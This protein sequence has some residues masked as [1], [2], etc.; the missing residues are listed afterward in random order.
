[1]QA[2]F[3]DSIHDF[4]KSDDMKNNICLVIEKWMGTKI[5]DSPTAVS[6]FIEKAM[7]REFQFDKSFKAGVNKFLIYVY[8]ITLHLT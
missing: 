5:T 2:A 7:E 4:A 6:E 1:M 3:S 8:F